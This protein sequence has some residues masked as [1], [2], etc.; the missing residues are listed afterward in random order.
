MDSIIEQLAEIEVAAEAIVDHAERQKS[1]IE[2][3][4]QAERDKFDRELEEETAKELEAIRSEAE[5]KMEKVLSGQKEKNQYMLDNLQ[6]EYEENHEIYA[7][8]IV[9]HIVEV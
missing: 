4:V 5:A 3:K 6:K 9:K 1:E 7:E 2:K 8:E